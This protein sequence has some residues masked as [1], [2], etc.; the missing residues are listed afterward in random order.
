MPKISRD[1]Y[2]LEGKVRVALRVIER[3]CCNPDFQSTSVTYL[4]KSKTKKKS[5]TFSP[6][7]EPAFQV[8]STRQAAQQ[9]LCLP[10]RQRCHFSYICPAFYTHTLRNYD[11]FWTAKHYLKD[12]Y[13]MPRILKW[14]VAMVSH[15]KNKI[16][17]SRLSEDLF[18]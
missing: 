7:P 10:Q 18:Y 14:Q 4:L 11:Y 6:P 8:C 1:M 5:T 12:R 3:P 2:G 16:R 13:Y 15:C 17:F 9:G